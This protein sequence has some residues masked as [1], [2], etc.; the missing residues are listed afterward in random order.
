MRRLRAIEGAGQVVALAAAEKVHVGVDVHKRSYHVAI[1]SA[2]RGWISTWVQPADNDLLLT[3]L[4][5]M[6]Q[7]ISHVVYEAGPT[8][9]S[10]VRAL[11]EAG[12]MADVIAPSKIPAPP[13]KEAK[14]DR[15]DCRKLAMFSGKG[16]LHAVKVPSEQQEAD[17]QVVRLREQ[18]VRK[19]RAIKLQIRSFLLQHGIAERAGLDHWP[20]NQSIPCANS[21]WV[22][23]C[24]SAWTCSWTS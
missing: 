14:S 2:E 6:R 15:I 4:G 19:K 24:G 22:P 21:S 13:G 17:R 12:Y 10:L 1:W 11:R 8:G 9:F 3:R 20:G 18:L 7:A 23:S 16:L 5:P